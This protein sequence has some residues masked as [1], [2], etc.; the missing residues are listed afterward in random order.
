MHRDQIESQLAEFNDE[1]KRDGSTYYEMVQDV[2]EALFIGYKA[3]RRHR[4]NKAVIF[5]PYSVD[6]VG[7]KPP[8]VELT[9]DDTNYVY[10]YPPPRD[11]PGYEATTPA[12]S[13]KEDQPQP[14]T[15]GLQKE[16]S[17]TK[18]TEPSRKS[19]ARDRSQKQSGS[20]TSSSNATIPITSSGE[21][22]KQ[23]RKSV[24]KK[25]KKKSS[26]DSEKK[27]SAKKDKEPKS[28]KQ[29]QSKSSEQQQPKTAQGSAEKDTEGSKDREEVSSPSR[30]RYAR[31]EQ[32]LAL[33]NK[34]LE[35]NRKTASEIARKTEELAKMREE[36]LRE[37]GEQGVTYM[38]LDKAL[39]KF[40]ALNKGNSKQ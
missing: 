15:S 7:R 32:K 3:G 8:P 21:E 26:K 34:V 14:S 35:T 12:G 40:I 33:A 19:V 18:A 30:L 10:E 29:K 38:Q 17:P 1:M 24:K 6:R 23:R 22:E 11:M 37:I 27:S 20:N 9:E 13:Q 5:E 36:V 25:K 2:Y 4:P 16:T 39:G 31:A 28:S